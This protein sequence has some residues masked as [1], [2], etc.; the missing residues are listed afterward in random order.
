MKNKLL[1]FLLSINVS[2][3][4]VTLKAFIEGIRDDYSYTV[5]YNFFGEA[6]IEIVLLII[7]FLGNI[8]LLA[9][10]PIWRG[11]DADSRNFRD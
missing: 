8:Y 6:Y 9:Q 10:N 1:I 5:Y 3:S 7:C 4:F 11:V 2:L